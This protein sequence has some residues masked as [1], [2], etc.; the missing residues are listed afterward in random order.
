MI[1]NKSELVFIQK[2][3]FWP[4]VAMTA[5]CFSGPIMIT[6]VVVNLVAISLQI[7]NIS[8]YICMKLYD[9]SDRSSS[10]R[11]IKCVYQLDPCVPSF[12]KKALKM[13]LV[14]VATDEHMD[15]RTDG[16]S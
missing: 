1:K 6:L 13:R 8:R 12:I 7:T 5:K 16:Q 4:I 9:L 15:T 14:C 3:S 11:H 2:P 10:F